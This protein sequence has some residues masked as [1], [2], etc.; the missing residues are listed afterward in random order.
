E[1]RDDPRGGDTCGDGWI[2]RHQLDEQRLGARGSGHGGGRGGRA[3]RRP[4]APQHLLAHAEPFGRE[5]REE[6]VLV[7]VPHALQELRDLPCGA[8]T[9]PMPACERA[10][11][12]R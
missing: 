1:L 9:S 4:L 2:C 10:M 7:R 6:V 12:S 3:R 5:T 8:T 11:T